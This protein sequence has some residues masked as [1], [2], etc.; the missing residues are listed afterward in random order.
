MIAL[1]AAL[2]QP[3]GLNAAFTPEQGSGV[4]IVQA[5]VKAP[6]D[7][8][9][10]EAAA[11]RVLGLALQEEASKRRVASLGRMGLEVGLP[12]KVVTLP[13]MM[14]IQ[15]GASPANLNAAID[16]IATLLGRVT[17][18]EADLQKLIDQQPAAPGDPIAAALSGMTWPEA[19]LRP[20]QVDNLYRFAFRQENTVFGIAGDLDPTAAAS[21]LDRALQRNQSRLPERGLRFDP[22]PFPVIESAGGVN[23]FE[24]RAKAFRNNAPDAPARI[25]AAFALG[26]GKSGTLFRV[27]RRELGLSYRQEA[28]LWPT[29]KGWE[30]RLMMLRTPAENDIEVL[31]KFTAAVSAD[32][33]AWNDDSLQRA[34]R[35]SEAAFTRQVESQVMWLSPSGPMGS[36]LADRSAWF[37]Y[38][39]LLS[40]QAGRLDELGAALRQVTVD[41][42]KAAAAQMLSEAGTGIIPARAA[43]SPDA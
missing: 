15:L 25:L 41:E 33:E 38:N 36:T 42:L 26:A 16:G 32:V 43:Q 35:L 18:R 27:L 14:L 10:R 7:I 20:D 13:D 28:V 4:V 29:Q 6:A 12:P 8:T 34:L 11:W 23:I 17:F 2:L 30:L 5:W 31:E 9:A 22:A 39:R 21:L 3:Q 37:A 24:M 19:T 40:P 1:A